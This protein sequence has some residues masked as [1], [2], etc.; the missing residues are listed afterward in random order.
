MSTR[1]QVMVKGSPIL[2]YK[3]CDGYPDGVLPFLTEFIARFVKNRGN[4]P[5]YFLAQ[6]LRHNA[7]S[8]EAEAKVGDWSKDKPQYWPSNT[9]TGWGL[10]CVV[11][12]DIEYLYVVDLTGLGSVE[13]LE[14]G[15]ELAYLNNKV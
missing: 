5:A 6:L 3:H 7:I 9:F 1:A 11:H 15:F 13:T 10:D 12:G 14:D 8:G 4:D 2:V